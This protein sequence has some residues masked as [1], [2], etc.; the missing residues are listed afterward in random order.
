MCA[1]SPPQSSQGCAIAAGSPYHDSTQLN[2]ALWQPAPQATQ[3]VQTAPSVAS[4]R[5]PSG[6]RS[7]PVDTL[8]QR[9]EAEEGD[10]WREALARLE[11]HETIRGNAWYVYVALRGAPNILLSATV[12]TAQ[13]R[14][15]RTMAPAKS[16][17]AAAGASSTTWGPQRVHT[18]SQ[19]GSIARPEPFARPTP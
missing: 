19:S 12:L 14:D 5:H 17:A 7:T 18:S 4:E 13:P 3:P 8:L 1:A 2:P 16:A 6:A 11:R 10:D 15:V 9:F